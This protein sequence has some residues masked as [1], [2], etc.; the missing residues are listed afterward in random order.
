MTTRAALNTQA[1]RLGA[2]IEDDSA[3][4]WNVLQCVAPDGEVWNDT[5]GIHIKIEWPRGS[6]K[7]QV[8]DILQD[9]INRMNAGT[10]EMTEREKY[11]TAEN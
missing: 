3:G 10:R 11:E 4:R 9:A 7:E 5:G 8:T 2:T 1:K 6:T